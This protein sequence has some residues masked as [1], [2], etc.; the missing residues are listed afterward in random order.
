MEVDKAL[1]F[2]NALNDLLKYTLKNKSK[3]SSECVKS[4]AA[5]KNRSDEYVSAAS[6]GTL[7]NMA[8]RTALKDVMDDIRGHV[9]GR[10]PASLSSDDFRCI[11]SKCLEDPAFRIWSQEMCELS[12]N[13]DAVLK[14]FRFMC[15]QCK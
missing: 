8:V 11:L 14:T 13:D 7:S 9:D 5:W 10:D 2:A 15:D 1:T 12:K 3:F 6:S 4:C